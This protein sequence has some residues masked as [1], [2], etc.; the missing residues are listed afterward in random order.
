SATVLPFLKSF[1]YPLF[2]LAA[3]LCLG[4]WLDTSLIFE[5][6]LFWIGLLFC[7]LVS[8]IF[9]F[10]EKTCRK[11]LLTRIWYGVVGIYVTILMQIWFIF[12]FFLIFVPFKDSYSS[13]ST[14]ALLTTISA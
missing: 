7:Y 5:S 4:I 14:K 11:S 2:F 8:F 1:G 9:V 13:V 12:L 10:S 6:T 3:V